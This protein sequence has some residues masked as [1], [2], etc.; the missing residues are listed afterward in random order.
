MNSC[1]E[2]SYFPTCWKTAF[3]KVLPKHNKADYTDVSAYRLIGLINVFGKL[4]G[5]LIIRRLNYHMHINNFHNKHQYGFKEQTSTV[6]ALNTAIN[7]IRQVK[8]EGQ[9]VVAVSLDIQAAFDNA[10]WPALYK[11]L[12]H[13]QCP[14]EPLQINSKL[15]S[16]QNCDTQLR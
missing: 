13:I 7:Y 16:K 1:I 15:H 8:Q 4:L 10:W 2:L 5:K 11:R 14:K 9:H 6:D 3:V 12:Q